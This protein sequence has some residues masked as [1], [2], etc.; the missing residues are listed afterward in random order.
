MSTIFVIWTQ[1]HPN[2]FRK[3]MN[4]KLYIFDLDD[5][6]VHYGRKITVP[7][8]TFHVLRNLSH[9]GHEIVVVS[10]NSLCEVIMV[11]TGLYKY[12]T[13]TMWGRDD[14]YML[15]Q[16]ALTK[17]GKSTLDNFTYVDDRLD[18]IQNIKLHFPC[19][20]TVYVENALT[21]YKRIPTKTAIAS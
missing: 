20:E 8:Q 3:K 16:R 13:M 17:A 4:K 6:L 11:I 7:R 15:V 2:E 21:L 10:Y 19:V 5:T 18:N 9:E 12:V 1:V 14:R